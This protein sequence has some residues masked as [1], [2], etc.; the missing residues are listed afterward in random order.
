MPRILWE[1]SNS[2]D[3]TSG[4]DVRKQMMRL[5]RNWIEKHKNSALDHE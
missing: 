3:T 5:N 4:D 1:L 2:G